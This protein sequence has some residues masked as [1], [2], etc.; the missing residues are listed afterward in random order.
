MPSSPSSEPTHGSTHP[1]TNSVLW[2]CVIFIIL[3]GVG[4]L[5]MSFRGERVHR[6]ANGNIVR[7]AQPGSLVSDFPSDIPLEEGVAIQNSYSIN[8]GSQ[9][10]HLPYVRYTSTKSYIDNIIQ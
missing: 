3:V 5:L 9:K 2:L 6:D 7:T 8:Y 1:H 10:T 4:V